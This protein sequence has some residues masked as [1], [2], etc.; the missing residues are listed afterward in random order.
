MRAVVV[1]LGLLG[2]DEPALSVLRHLPAHTEIRLEAQPASA[3]RCPADMVDVAGRFCID[4]FEMRVFDR[5]SE[6]PLSPYYHPRAD[7]ALR[8][9]EEWARRAP[10]EG[11]FAARLVLLPELPEQQR[12]GK[13]VIEARSEPNVLPS[14]YLD[15]ESARAA[16]ESAGKRLC[17]RDEWETAC[18]GEHETRHPYGADFDPTRCNVG[19]THPSAI[20]HG[21]SELGPLDP[22]LNLVGDE[23]GDLLA[24]TGVYSDCASSWGD[25]AVYDMV[26]NLDEWID[27]PSG[28]FLGG[29]YARDT[30]WGC[31]MRIEIHSADYYDYSLGARCCR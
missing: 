23:R 7:L 13:A 29:F 27:D 2:C 31:D 19:R 14:A 16:C 12:S 17:R 26:G 24:A 21:K 25:D 28:V 11:S 15:L 6:Q 5:R 1:A 8:D 4:R 9:H 30:E 20:L 22:R 3:R 18:R 10:R